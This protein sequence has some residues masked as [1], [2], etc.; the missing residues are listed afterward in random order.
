[1]NSLN[2]YHFQKKKYVTLTPYD[3]K[4]ILPSIKS[5]DFRLFKGGLGSDIS[6][7]SFHKKGIVIKLDTISAILLENDVYFIKLENNESLNFLNYIYNKKFDSNSV[8]TTWILELMLIFLSEELDKHINNF[9]IKIKQYSIDQ[10]KMIKLSQI[11]YFHHSVMII[12]NKYQEIY[13][14][15]KEIVDEGEHKKFYLNDNNYDLNEEDNLLDTYINQ[16]GEDVKNLNRLISQINIFIDLIT[17]KLSEYRN[18]LAVSQLKFTIFSIILSIGTY[19]YSIF[20]MNM[21]SGIG[22]LV[23]GLWIMVAISII[24]SII[25]GIIIW[26][27]TYIFN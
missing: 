25:S 23:G 20:G 16:F 1:M 24:L 19:V 9:S 7:I 26:K 14:N 3:I 15:L 11:S 22:D 17:I 21:E 12:K 2:A 6:H 4:N 27:C 5:R 8:F 10:F 13:E 18:K